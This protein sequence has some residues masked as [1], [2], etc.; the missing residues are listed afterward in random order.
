M[1]KNTPRES[2]LKFIEEIKSKEKR[3]STFLG[4]KII[5]HKN[6]F[7][8]DSE[9]SFSSKITAK[10]IPNNINSVLDVGTGTG[11]QSIIAAKKGAKK[12]LAID[13]DNNCLINAKE[14]I[15]F[16][17]LEKIISIRKSNLFKKV[18]SIEKFDL[19]ISQLPFADVNYKSKV[20]HFLFD[21][22][23]KLHQNFLKS[24]KNHLT[25]NG[26]IFIPSGEIANE[27]KLLELIK[28]MIIKF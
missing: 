10:R 8:V 13:I 28:N 14:N 26:K 15:K 4:E 1:K 2:T 6:V 12:V 27:K 7:P 22:G 16:H 3:I 20:S 24:A 19:I 21:D 9:F 17:E 18:K 23:F 11:V 25:K 5:I